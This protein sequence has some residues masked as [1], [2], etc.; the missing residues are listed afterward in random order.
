M[1]V[2]EGSKGRKWTKEA[3]QGREERKGGK[4]CKKE[5]RKEGR[6]GSES[7]K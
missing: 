1:E 2:K 6:K 4:K 3:N 7:R 5:G